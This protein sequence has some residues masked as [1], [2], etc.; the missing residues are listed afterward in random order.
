MT[1]RI[2]NED[3]FCFGLE[4]EFMLVDAKTFRPLWHHDLT[5]AELNETLESI[6][7]DDLPSLEGLDLEPPHRKLMP[8]AVEG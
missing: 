1:H 4:A 3:A 8:F 5:F 2:N 6:P 7:F